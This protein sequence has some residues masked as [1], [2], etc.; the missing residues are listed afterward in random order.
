MWLYRFSSFCALLVL[1][2]SPWTRCFTTVSCSENWVHWPLMGGLCQSTVAAW[3][4]RDE[5]TV[6]VAFRL[7]SRQSRTVS[8]LRWSRCLCRSRIASVS[9]YGQRTRDDVMV[10]STLAD[11]LRL[12]SWLES[13]VTL[14]LR[15][16]ISKVTRSDDPVSLRSCIRCAFN[17]KSL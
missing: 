9:S 12:A 16:L 5:H 3:I 6:L 17:I 2:S 4:T 7:G 10:I 8:S 11:F 1:V 13:H 15:F 14:H